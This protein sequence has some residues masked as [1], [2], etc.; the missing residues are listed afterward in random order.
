MIKIID[1]YIV[2]ELIKPFIMVI[3]AFIVVMISV[4]LGEDV[5]S[6]IRDKIP[7]AV[8]LKTIVSKIPDYIIQALPV[9]YLM[10]TLLTTSRFSRDH[11][12][13]ALRAAGVKFKRLMV[14]ILAASV[15]ISV[16]S[17][18]LNEEVVPR[19]NQYSQKA[20]DAFKRLKKEG[21]LVTNNIYFR[22][23]DNR[24]FHV[25]KVDRDRKSMDNVV[26]ANTD[27]N[28]DRTII[29]AKSGTWNGMMWTL[30]EGII[31]HY[32]R[33]SEFVFREEKFTSKTI[34]SKVKIEDVINELKN[35]QEMSAVKLKEI[36]ES[37]KQSGFEEKELEIDYHLHYAKACATFFSATISAPMGFI[38]ARLGNYIGVALS[39][40]LIFIYFVTESMGRILG[41]NGIVSP[42]V[43][44]WSSNIV[45]AVN[46]LILLWQVDRR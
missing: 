24:F 23:T 14:P 4:R 44:A 21:G 41:I 36:I 20:I 8:V 17:F 15:V 7:V 5:D 33:D 18:F 31:Q 39:I 32:P 19:T 10:A 25:Q 3:M 29:V 6:I 35:P 22:G 9:G 11:E 13:T 46:G 16:I 26:I 43:A 28:Q 37:R 2:T 42:M 40:I 45:F 30:N 38:F 1:K 12:T 34:D 27:I